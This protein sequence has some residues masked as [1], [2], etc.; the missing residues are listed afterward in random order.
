MP[1]G[2]SNLLSWRDWYNYFYSGQ[3]VSEIQ[4]ALFG[5]MVGLYGWLITLAVGAIAYFGYKKRFG[6]V[7]LKWIVFIPVMAIALVRVLHSLYAKFVGGASN[8]VS[9]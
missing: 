7:W 1:F 6:G 5:T 9:V 2:P 8:T 3:F 4:G